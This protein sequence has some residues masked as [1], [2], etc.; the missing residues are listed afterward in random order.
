MPAPYFKSKLVN[1]SIVIIRKQAF[2]RFS[3]AGKHF[4]KTHDSV[5]DGN[6]LMGMAIIKQY[7]VT[8]GILNHLLHFSDVSLQLSE[9]TGK[10]NYDMCEFRAAEKIVLPPYLQVMVR[11][12]SNSEIS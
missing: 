10:Y 6:S 2:L 12:C 11:V 7:S 3:M 1:G 5:N 9:A 4:Q 8:L